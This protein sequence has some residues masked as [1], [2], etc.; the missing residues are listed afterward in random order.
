LYREDQGG[1]IG[2][3]TLLGW[4]PQ[5]LFN[6]LR[7]R[8]NIIEWVGEVSYQN[9]EI[10]PSMG[11]GHFPG[12]HGGKAASFYDCFGFNYDGRI[13][14]NFYKPIPFVDRPECYKISRWYASGK[15]G[16]QHF[17]YGGPGGCSK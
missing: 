9:N 2:G 1:P 7:N 6:S 11:N 3:T 13:Y 5:S 16:Y 12:E 8:A 10:A 17:Y 14:R 4:W 15:P